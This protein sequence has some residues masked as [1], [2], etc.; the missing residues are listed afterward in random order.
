MLSAGSAAV[1]AILSALKAGQPEQAAAVA[2]EVATALLKVCQQPSHYYLAALHLMLARV[3]VRHP[4]ILHQ[5]NPM[6]DVSR[7]LA[8]SFLQLIACSQ[9]LNTYMIKGE[10]DLGISCV[11]IAAERGDDIALTVPVLML[12][13]RPCKNHHGIHR[14]KV[15]NSAEPN[16]RLAALSH[17]RPYSFIQT[18][19]E[20]S[21]WSHQ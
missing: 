7:W 10:A 6:V 13:V 21:P 16:M 5:G 8:Q 18:S 12:L 19:A 3:I 20:Y 11:C 1:R 4:A 9:S 15:M 14:R 2:A 17:G